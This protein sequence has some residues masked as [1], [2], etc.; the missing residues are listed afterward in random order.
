MTLCHDK[1]ITRHT[2]WRIGMGR[3]T[4]HRKPPILIENPQFFSGDE[5]Q[6]SCHSRFRALRLHRPIQTWCVETPVN[7][8]LSCSD[9]NTKHNRKSRYSSVV[10]WIKFFCSTPPLACKSAF[11]RA[12]V[13]K[14]WLFSVK[15]SQRATS[16]NSYQ[17]GSVGHI[18][19]SCFISSAGGFPPWR[20][21]GPR[22]SDLSCGN[23]PR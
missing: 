3:L 8:D 13:A 2:W 7:Y 4:F 6:Q 17:F 15:R 20:W 23:Q 5:A 11:G 10:W 12:D 18:A 22:P 9:L 14:H 1:K 21:P 19:V 16:R